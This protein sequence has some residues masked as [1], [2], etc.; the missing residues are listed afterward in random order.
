MNIFTSFP[1]IVRIAAVG[2][3]VI[4]SVDNVAAQQTHQYDPMVDASPGLFVASTAKPF[5]ILMTDAMSIM[6]N[7][8]KQAPMNGVAEH[9]FITMMI[10]H[11]QGAI[12]MAKA[13]LVYTKDPELRNLAQSIITDQ[14]NEIAV[15]KAWLRRYKMR[16]ADKQAPSSSPGY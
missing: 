10:P 3:I 9:D 14:Q 13:L 12:D 2:I 8:M 4:F 5:S 7:G 6:N 15:M 11:H 1:R 16:G